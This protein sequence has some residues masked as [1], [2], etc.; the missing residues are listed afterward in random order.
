LNISGISTTPTRASF[1]P[2]LISLHPS[3][4]TASV[5]TLATQLHPEP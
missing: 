2:L 4:S 1:A 3:Q 5:R